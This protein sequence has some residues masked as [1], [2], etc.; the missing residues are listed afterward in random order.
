MDTLRTAKPEAEGLVTAEQRKARGDQLVAMRRVALERK[1]ARSKAQCEGS[2]GGIGI[3]LRV[4]ALKITM[5]ST[6]YDVPQDGRARRLRDIN[7]RLQREANTI[8]RGV[9]QRQWHAQQASS[10]RGI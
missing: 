8:R 9:V 5:N 6:T 2:V 3:L 7:E 10:R 1:L 4:Q